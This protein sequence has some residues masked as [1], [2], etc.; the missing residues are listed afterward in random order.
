MTSRSYTIFRDTVTLPTELTGPYRIGSGIADETD[1]REGAQNLDHGQDA[2]NHLLPDYD[3]LPRIEAWLR[4]AGAQL[5][6]LEGELVEMHRMRALAYASGIWVDI[7][8][9]IVGEPRKGRTD[10]QYKPYIQIRILTN[11]SAGLP[12]DLYAILL[13]GLTGNTVM[14]ITYPGRPG[15]IDAV[16]L[17]D[18]GDLDPT[19]FVE[20]LKRAKPAGKVI[21]FG[22]THSATDDTLILGG[23]NVVGGELGG[24]NVTGDDVGGLVG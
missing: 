5:T 6:Q 13:L 17:D 10:A 3:A 7:L 15:A 12:S 20:Y 16:A 11:R 8:G 22:Y 23:T 9:A 18:I 2:I 21:K 1:I 4:A 19:D 24:T 14:L